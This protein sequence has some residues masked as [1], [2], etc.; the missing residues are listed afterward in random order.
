M[1]VGATATADLDLPIDGRR[2]RRER[3]RRAVTDAMIEL[4]AEGHSPPTVEQVAARAGV[5]VASLFRYF[6]TLDELRHETTRRY[7]ERYSQLFEIPDIGAGPLDMRIGRLVDA[8]HELYETIEPMARFVRRQAPVVPDMN[9]TLHRTRSTMAE[10]IRRH[11]ETELGA[12]TAARRDDL[13]AVIST[14]TSFESWAQLGDDHDRS[15]IQI[16]RAWVQ[17]LRCLLRPL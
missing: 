3:G 9:D 17:T 11:F 5:S 7:V 1:T 4:V 2:A 6:E 12:M 14:L 10:Q 16:R 13:V 15:P 8:R